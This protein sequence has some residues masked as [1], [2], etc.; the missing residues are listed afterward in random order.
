MI[1][2]ESNH[3]KHEFH[4]NDREVECFDDRKEKGERERGKMIFLIRHLREIS[5]HDYHH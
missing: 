3:K 1:N 5:K 4:G 2:L